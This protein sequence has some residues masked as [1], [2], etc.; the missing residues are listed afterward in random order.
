MIETFDFYIRLIAIGAGLMLLALLVEGRMRVTIKVTLVGLIMGAIAYLINSSP[1]L[2]PSGLPDIALDLVA[3]SPPFWSW[4]FARRLF[5]REPPRAATLAAVIG[6]TVSWFLGNFFEIFAW[7]GFYVIHVISLVLIADLLR[8]AFQDRGDDLIEKR[9]VIR[10]VLPLL[11]AAQAG[12]ILTYE[13]ILGSAVAV[14]IVQLMNAVLILLITL[15]A[16][17]ALFRTDPELLI[18]SMDD[19][20]IDAQMPELDLSPSDAVLH[21]KLSAAM[22]EGAFREPGLT[23]TALAEALDAP[24]HKLRALINRQMGYRNFSAFL[25]QHRIAEAKSKLSERDL[26]DMP[27]LT[28]AMDLGYNSLATFNRAF[29]SQTGQTPSEYRRLMIGNG[30]AEPVEIP[31]ESAVQ[32]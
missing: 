17:L 8:V 2:E 6:L 20:I 7:P 13:I 29:K 26:V 5:E 30:Q 23:I 31:P 28:I 3:L 12:M 27:V 1:V 16:G 11:I 10:L 32:N 4:I 15:F 18:Q 19:P 14:P 25:N 22:T 21:E 9:R 24:E